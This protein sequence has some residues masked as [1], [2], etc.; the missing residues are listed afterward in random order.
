MQVH[1]DQVSTIVEEPFG[2][3]KRFSASMARVF[4][5]TGDLYFFVIQSSPRPSC[6]LITAARVVAALRLSNPKTRAR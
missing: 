3:A 6:S 2:M 5:E 4:P 1:H